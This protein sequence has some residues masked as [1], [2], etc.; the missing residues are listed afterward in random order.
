MTFQIKVTLRLDYLII[1]YSLQL[2]H[3]TV[4]MCTCST[5]LRL[6]SARLCCEGTLVNTCYTQTL[7]INH[8]QRGE[9]G[10]RE[11]LLIMI[12]SVV[13]FYQVRLSFFVKTSKYLYSSRALKKQ[14]AL[15]K[16][17]NS[18]HVHHVYFR[19]CFVYHLMSQ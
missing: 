17:I 15:L 10:M 7:C 9:A 12:G 13:R 8:L 2:L 5:A 18:R 6:Y 16:I 19:L 1:L 4:Y 11:G 14:T 3:Y